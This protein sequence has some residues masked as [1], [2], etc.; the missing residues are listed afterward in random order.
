MAILNVIFFQKTTIFSPS[1]PEILTPQPI[2]CPSS[3]PLL[4]TSRWSSS[5]SACTSRSN[6]LSLS[7]P[8]PVV[9]PP[10]SRLDSCESAVFSESILPTTLVDKKKILKNADT[11]PIFLKPMIPIHR[12]GLFLFAEEN[13]S[14][15]PGWRMIY[16]MLQQ[17]WGQKISR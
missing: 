8:R 4:P 5:V 11:A 6:A 2:C 16:K 12:S 14:S 10:C 15:F 1:S 3:P 7:S 13:L 9:A 17:L